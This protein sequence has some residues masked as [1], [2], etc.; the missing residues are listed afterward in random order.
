MVT[1]VT[2]VVIHVCRYTY[3]VFLFPLSKKLQITG[4]ILVKPPNILFHENSS[5]RSQVIPQ[6]QT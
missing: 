4:Q 1:I 5:S 6:E 2:K 3:K